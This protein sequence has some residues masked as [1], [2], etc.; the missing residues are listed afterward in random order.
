MPCSS[1]VAEMVGRIDGETPVNKLMGGLRQGLN[2]VQGAQLELSAIA[3][4]HV[5]YVD[6]TI[7]E[8]RGI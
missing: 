4:L 2:E 7:A 8:L 6:G 5:L 3:A 1:L